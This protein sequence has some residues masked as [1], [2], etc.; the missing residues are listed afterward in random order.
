[1]L[2]AHPK[3]VGHGLNLQ[4]GGHIIVWFTL[5]YSREDYE[6]M[7]CRLA[8]RGQ[9]EIVLIYRLIV[10]KSI[11]EVVAGVVESKAANEAKL[12]NALTMLESM[13]D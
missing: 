3:S 1:M 10:P 12:L 4:Y 13:R 8:R 5:T 9:K 11:D 7:I 6:Q 2:V